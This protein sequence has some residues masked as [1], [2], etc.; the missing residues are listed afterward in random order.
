MCFRRQAP[1]LASLAD[2]VR[3]VYHVNPLPMILLALLNQ[4]HL[5]TELN[6]EIP[7]R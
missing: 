1:K 6:E 7:C 5:A 4:T 3:A 2:C